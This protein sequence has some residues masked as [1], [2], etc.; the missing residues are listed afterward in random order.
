MNNQTRKITTIGMLCA[1][2]YVMMAVELSDYAAL[3]GIL[4][5]SG[6]RIIAPGISSLQFVKKRIKCSAYICAV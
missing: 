5:R 6:C 1:V 4:K 2:T 3:Y